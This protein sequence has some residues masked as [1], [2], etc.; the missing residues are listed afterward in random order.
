MELT[1]EEIAQKFR[2]RLIWVLPTEKVNEEMFKE[3][4]SGMIREYGEQQREAE[5]GKAYGKGYNDGQ[6]DGY[7]TGFEDGKTGYKYKA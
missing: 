7:K 1:P 6:V 3:V 2:D 5:Y 4:L